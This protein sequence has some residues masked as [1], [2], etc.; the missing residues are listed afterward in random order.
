M[1]ASNGPLIQ[2]LITALG[3]P[4]HC[5]WFEL[6]AAVNEPVTVKCAYHP[7]PF[8][9]DD[10]IDI[11]DLDSTAREKVPARRGLKTVLAEYRLEPVVG[12]INRTDALLR[13]ASKVLDHLK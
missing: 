5:V 6:R 1:I 13:M 11:S 2:E 9:M 12:D 8:A 7:D 3:L 10:V 4:K